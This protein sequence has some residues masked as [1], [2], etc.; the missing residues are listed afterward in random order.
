MT[1]GT[2]TARVTVPADS[3]WFEGHFP[4][5]PVLPGIAQLAMV[6]QILCEVLK[7]PVSVT[8]VSRV[9]FKQA[10]M[11]AEPVEVQITPRENDRLAC[12]FRL[13][14]ASELACSGF[15]KLVEI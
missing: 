12:G 7:K 11:P 13:L 10:I 15:L 6:V 14:K 1:D 2:I 3:V 8:D 4:G 9:R 5:A